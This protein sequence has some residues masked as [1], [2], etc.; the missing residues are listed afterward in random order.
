MLSYFRNKK[1]HPILCVS[2]LFKTIN[3]S[4]VINIK[5]CFCAMQDVFISREYS[6][7]DIEVNY[8]EKNGKKLTRFINFLKF[9]MWFRL[10]QVLHQNV[11]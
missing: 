4:D 3:Q 8:G 9:V 6:M 2:K 11:P 7:T 1:K 5:P 10:V